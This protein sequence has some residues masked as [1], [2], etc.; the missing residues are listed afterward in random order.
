VAIGEANDE[1]A[2]TKPI[3][4]LQN[5]PSSHTKIGTKEKVPSEIAYTKDGIEWGSS[6]HVD[7]ALT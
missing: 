5:W 2:Q 7:E 1:G 6:I 3:Q 4:V